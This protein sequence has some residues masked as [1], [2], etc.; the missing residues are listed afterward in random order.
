MRS[1]PLLKNSTAKEAVATA[2]STLHQQAKTATEG[3]P[4]FSGKHA[5]LQ[6]ELQVQSVMHGQP[7][8]MSNSSL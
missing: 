1:K 8:S 7:E 6:D 5:L 2:L 4:L 3:K